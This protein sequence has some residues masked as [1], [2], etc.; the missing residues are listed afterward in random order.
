MAI[1]SSTRQ[2]HYSHKPLGAHLVEAGLLTEAQV[3][4]ALADQNLTALPF[5]EIVVA[6]GWVKEQTIEYLF[7]KIILPE[8]GDLAQSSAEMN[9]CLTR[10]QR[11]TSVQSKSAAQKRTKGEGTIPWI[12]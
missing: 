5:G 10:R 12:G 11:S 3:G 6:R 9:D 2:L 1:Q 7:Q 4:V 8:R